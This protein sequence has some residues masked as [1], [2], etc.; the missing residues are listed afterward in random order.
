M[1]VAHT[2]SA[3]ALLGLTVPVL[4]A[5]TAPADR[6]TFQPREGSSAEKTF[7]SSF[8]LARTSSTTTS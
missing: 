5:L 3:A 1:K 7:T 4:M 8:S 2:I 6:I